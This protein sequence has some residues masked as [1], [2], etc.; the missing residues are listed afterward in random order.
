MRRRFYYNT[1]LRL[2][3]LFQRN[4][5]YAF[6]AFAVTPAPIFLHVFVRAQIVPDPRAQFAR[7]DAVDDLDLLQSVYQRLIQKRFH[8]GDAFENRLPKHVDFRLRRAA[9]HFFADRVCMSSA[10]STN[11][12]L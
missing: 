9:L 6:F 4:N 1:I 11:Q 7:A 8:I 3:Q 5:R 12:S 10:G 2:F